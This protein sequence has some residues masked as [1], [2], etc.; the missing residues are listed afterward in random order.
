VAIPSLANQRQVAEDLS[1]V[2]RDTILFERYR[3][4]LLCQKRALMQRLLSM[5]MPESR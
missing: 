3:D 1:L 4:A 2:D 5:P